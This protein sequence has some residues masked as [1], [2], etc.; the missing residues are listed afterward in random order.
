MGFAACLRQTCFFWWSAAVTKV[1]CG[2]SNV[3]QGKLA[4]RACL[5]AW[6]QR[7]S[8][9]LFPRLKN[10]STTVLHSVFVVSSSCLYLMLAWVLVRECEGV[11][12]CVHVRLS[13]AKLVGTSCWERDVVL[14]VATKFFREKMCSYPIPV[15]EVGLQGAY[16]CGRAAKCEK[17]G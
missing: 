10:S 12:V 15:Y 7:I 17:S 5:C 1:T 8:P 4:E 2:A 13:V 16:I 3:W 11:A 9:A 6:V 14:N